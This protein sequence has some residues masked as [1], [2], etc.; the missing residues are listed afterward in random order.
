MGDTCQ[1][2]LR[3]KDCDRECNLCSCST[4]VGTT[5]EHCSGH[6]HCEASCTK[7]SCSGAKCKCEQGWT[8]NK[9]ETPGNLECY[10]KIVN[11]EILWQ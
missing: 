10:I 9:C 6:G 5:R 3:W 8:G 7:T 11:L 1:N 2:L 4:S